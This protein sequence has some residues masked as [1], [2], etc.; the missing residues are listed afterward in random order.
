MDCQEM[1]PLL[2]AFIDGELDDATRQTV[3]AHVQSCAARRDELQ[4]W[5]QLKGVTDMARLAKPPDAVWERYW[6][7]VY[8]RLER[9][10]GWILASLGAIICLS[11]A[12]WEFSQK[13]VDEFLLNPA[14]P[15]ILRV[16]VVALILGGIILFVSILRERLTLRRSERYKE[17]IR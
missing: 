12:A 7:G 10:I 13:F 4:R 9:N 6:T 1:Q 8:N 3:E 15:L 2:M 17:I 16:G 11:W 14:E 5:Q